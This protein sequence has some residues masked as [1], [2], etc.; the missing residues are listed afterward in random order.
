VQQAAEQVGQEA[1]RAAGQAKG[2]LV[3]E[4]GRRSSQ[5]GGQLGSTASDVRAAAAELRRIGKEQPASLADQAADRLEQLG[6]YL[7]DSGGQR[8]LNDIEDFARRQPWA[9]VA[10]GMALGLIMSRFLKASSSERYRRSTSER[11]PATS[12]TAIKSELVASYGTTTPRYEDDIREGGVLTS[13]VAPAY[14]ATPAERGTTGTDPIDLS[15][16]FESTS[17]TER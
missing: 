12:E 14:E 17:P 10:G 8:I 13:G 5:A 7:R 4:I 6:G 16:Q 9:V 1:Q 3:Q 2:R 15:T 11:Y